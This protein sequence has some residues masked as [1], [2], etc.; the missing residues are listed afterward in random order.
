MSDRINGLVVTLE[1]DYKDKDA[2]AI[3]CAIGM[4]K[5]VISVSTNV[6]DYKDHINR[7]QIKMELK[8]KLRE[9]MEG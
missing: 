1:E 7:Q 8:Q 3:I 9:A 6:V 5:G 4:I 2:E